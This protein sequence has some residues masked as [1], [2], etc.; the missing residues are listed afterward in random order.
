M[1]H[2]TLI[3]AM[4]ATLPSAAQIADGAFEGGSP[5]TDWTEAST[6]FG[7]PF[8]TMAACAG[9]ENPVFRP[10]NGDFFL[11]F[12]G[13]GAGGTF[14]EEASV[15]QTCNII[16]GP[17]VTLSMWVKYVAPGNA[18]DFFRVLVDGNMV[19]EIVPADS[20]DYQEYTGVGF[21]VS[22]FAGGSHTVRLES[23]QANATEIQNLLVD[24]VELLADGGSIGLFEN[25]ALPGIQVYPN[26]ASNNITLGFNA[27][28]GEGVVTINDL[29]G[30]VIDTQVLSEV[31]QRTF[32]Y[33]ANSL[34]NGVYVVSV[35]NAGST[36]TQ[37]VMV[38]H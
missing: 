14:P 30:K 6:N 16:S 1:K 35:V 22:S 5:S 33:D 26:P 21:D 20:L 38:A 23:S 13:A 3:A 19:G 31:N 9:G 12:G 15:E 24:Q 34:Q 29:S 28:R 7:T 2:I 10:F 17:S 8:C 27:L 18:A 36:Y 37:R 4:A 11:W 25:E 32:N